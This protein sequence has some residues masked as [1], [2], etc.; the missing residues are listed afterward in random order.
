MTNELDPKKIAQLLTQSTRQ[1]DETILSAL[2]NARQ[3]ALKRYSERAP[4]F[5]LT[6]ASAHQSFGWT[7]ALIPRSAQRW[8]AAG[9]FFAVLIAGMGIW[10]NVQEQQISELD[11][12]ILTDDLPIEVFVD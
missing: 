3:N 6:P 8:I 2:V 4:V 5:A 1:M 7:D 10:H 11:V 12:A 9:L